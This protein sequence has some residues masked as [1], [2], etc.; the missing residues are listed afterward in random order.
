MIYRDKQFHRAEISKLS[1]A[2]FTHNFIS[3]FYISIIDSFNYLLAHDHEE[4][5]KH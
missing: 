1:K 5:Q 4:V 2:N 3:N